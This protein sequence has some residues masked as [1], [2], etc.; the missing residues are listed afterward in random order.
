M[1]KERGRGKE[2]GGKREKERGRKREKEREKER[3]RG[4]KGG[5]SA[6]EEKKREQACV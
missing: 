5:V 2:V 6:R 3:E 1:Y 4:G